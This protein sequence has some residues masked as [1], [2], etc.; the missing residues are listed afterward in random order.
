MVES[1]NRTLTG[2][3]MSK[4]PFFLILP[5]LLLLPFGNVYHSY[6]TNQACQ[7]SQLETN[8]SCDCDSMQGQMVIAQDDSCCCVKP[9]KSVPTEINFLLD[10]KPIVFEFALGF[11][12]STPYDLTKKLNVIDNYATYYSSGISSTEKFE[13]YSPPIYQQNCSLRI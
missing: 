3:S 12:F 7:I 5:L 2:I 8:S 11:E 13:Y 1:Q 6:L 4:I 10:A 9:S